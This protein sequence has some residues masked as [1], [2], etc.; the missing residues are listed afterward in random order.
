[1]LKNKFS[2]KFTAH[3]MSI[4]A[5]L[6]A[7]H[8]ILSRFLS[9]NLN[10]FMRI[11][12]GFLPTAVAGMLLGP[13]PAMLTGGLGDVIGYL[14]HPTG[15][16]HFGF[17][18][19]AICAGL[20]Y[21][22]FFYETKVTLVHVLLSKLLIDVCLNLGLNTLWIH[23]LYGKAITVLLPSRAVKNLCQ[24]PVDVILLFSVATLVKRIPARYIPN[25]K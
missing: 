15:A 11:S 18:L 7:L 8:I 16:Y 4:I 25:M 22:L 9:I 10:E 13:L 2:I 23:Q 17:T 24:Y 6:V 21:G 5:M 20:V 14:L 1:M 3:N 12:F 19:T